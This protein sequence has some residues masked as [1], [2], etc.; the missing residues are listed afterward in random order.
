[1]SIG[2]GDDMVERRKRD[3]GGGAHTFMGFQVTLSH[4]HGLSGHNF[5]G[6]QVSD[7]A[8]YVDVVVVVVAVDIVVAAE[9]IMETFWM[10]K[11]FSKDYYTAVCIT[12]CQVSD[13]A[14]KKASGKCSN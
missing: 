1:M 5:I 9:P 6:F 10:I 2:E 8:L 13:P 7:S 4:I 14:G 11:V 3:W 12:D